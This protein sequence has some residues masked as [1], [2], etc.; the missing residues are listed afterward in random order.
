[1]EIGIFAKTFARPTLEEVLDAIRAHGFGCVQ[2]NLVCAGLPPLPD[3]IDPGVCDHIRACM[4]DRGI[5]MGAISGTFN[6]TDPDLEKRRSGLAR[7]RVLIAACKRLGTSIV[8]I[9]TGTRDP[10]D[11]WRRHPENS[12]P[13]A[14]RDLLDSVSEAV[15][16][17]EEAGITL[18][19]E[20]EVANV[21]DSAVKARRLLDE[22]RSSRLKVVI[23]PANLFHSG[24]LPRM[25]EILDEAFALLGQDIVLAHAKDLSRD[26][27]AGHEAAGTGRL[28]YDRYLSLLE[29]AG[30]DGPLILH[31]LSEAQVSKSTGF[32][33]SK[34][35][36]LSHGRTG[37]GQTPRSSQTST[38]PTAKGGGTG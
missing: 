10:E 2:F 24:E 22:I 14:W 25:R 21:V 1:M 4:A 30:F 20:P 3:R 23:D 29:T 16:F 19:F 36:L 38:C 34:L 18:A 27:E 7:L 5:R 31:G 32:L 28:D 9:C 26:G 37:D 35:D 11:M 15:R 8:T 6:M 13:H 12:S 33:R 17:A